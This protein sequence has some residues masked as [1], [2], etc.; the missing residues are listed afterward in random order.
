M[1]RK[2]DPVLL[3]GEAVFTNDMKVPGAL[4]MAVLR[5]PYAHATIVAIDTSAAAAMPGV[6]AVYTGADLS[7]LWAAPMP[8]AWPVTDDMLNPPHHPIATDTVNYVGDGVAVVLADS[9]AIAHDAIEAIDVTY[10][11][12]EAITDLEDALCRPR[13]GASRARHQLLVHLEPAGRGDRRRRPA[14]VR[15]RQPTRSASATSSSA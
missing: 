13:P 3:T 6:R 10:D 9:D 14:G 4:H 1:L 12:H 11:A 7:D 15:R 8:C 5:S 2:E